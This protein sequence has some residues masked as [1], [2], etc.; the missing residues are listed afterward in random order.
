MSEGKIFTASTFSSVKF[1]VLCHGKLKVFGIGFK[2]SEQFNMS[3]LMLRTHLV[4]VIFIQ[5]YIASSKLKYDQYGLVAKEKHL[6]G[7]IKI[8]Y[9]VII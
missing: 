1:I 6:S 3:Q 4:F 2:K 5:Q 9:C 7:K 8:M